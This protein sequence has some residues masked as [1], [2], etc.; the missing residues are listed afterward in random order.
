[1]RRADARTS[2]AEAESTQSKKSS[3]SKT[4]RTPREKS[5]AAQKADL[6]AE[7]ERALPQQ[8]ATAESK[9]R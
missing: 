8:R 2:T 6:Q 5:Q 7:D 3:R 9:E 1:M 4:G